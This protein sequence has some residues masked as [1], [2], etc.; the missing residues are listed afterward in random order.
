[1]NLRISQATHKQKKRDGD[2]PRN[3]F[4]C[5]AL[6]LSK[7]LGKWT[8]TSCFRNF[9]FWTRWGTEYW[10]DCGHSCIEWFLL[11]V[12][13]NVCKFPIILISMNETCMLTVHIGISSAS[14]MLEGMMEGF[15]TLK[16]ILTV[17]IILKTGKT[18]Q[19]IGYP[20]G[21]AWHSVSI[22]AVSIHWLFK[23]QDKVE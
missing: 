5:S 12:G 1:M 16:I 22:E 7:R 18:K 15:L 11:E 6:F 21:K 3:L 17:M 2:F 13:S 23:G 14:V 20:C 9:N 8:V 10:V 19:D 4:Y